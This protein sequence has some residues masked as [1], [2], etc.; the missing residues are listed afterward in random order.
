MS[1]D[2]KPTA[3]QDQNP[4]D[5]VEFQ[6]VKNPDAVLAKNKELLGK[7]KETGDKLKEMEKQLYSLKSE[8]LTAE[9]RKDEL[10]ETLKEQLEV[11]KQKET[12]LTWKAVSR[13]IGIEA[14]KRGCKNVDTLMKVV[15]FKNASIDM[16]SFSVAADD[17]N[18]I[19]EKATKEH[20][21]LFEKDLKGPRDAGPSKK[22]EAPAKSIKEMSA[23]EL[24]QA[25]KN[26]RMKES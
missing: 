6:E 8:K 11:S 19:L 22:V 23:E 21:Y 12:E 2:A 3:E 1:K 17:I 13:Q 14:T 4:T 5:Q 15:D 16:E 26:I 10:I 7:L 18:M 9:G 20:D 25:F 24:A